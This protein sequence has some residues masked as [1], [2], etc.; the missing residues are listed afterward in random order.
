MC[1]VLNDG[2][3]GHNGLSWS[4]IDCLQELRE[5]E[6]EG[7]DKEEKE[8]KE[9][10]KSILAGSFELIMSNSRLACVCEWYMLP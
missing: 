6:G 10:R 9:K 7:E 1:P 8:R 4:G 2:N 5:M 3:R